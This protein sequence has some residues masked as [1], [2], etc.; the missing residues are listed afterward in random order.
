MGCESTKDVFYPGDIWVESQDIL[1]VFE[2][3]KKSAELIQNK[4]SVISR[5]K[6]EL[7]DLTYTSENI[8]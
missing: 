6:D 8:T 7:K 3:G 1:P 5:L 4:F 2:A